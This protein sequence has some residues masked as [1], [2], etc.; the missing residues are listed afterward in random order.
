MPNLVIVSNRLPVSVKKTDGKLEFYPS[1]GGLARGLI[2][3]TKKR[4]TKWIG[5]PGIPSD[6]LS[7]SER[8]EIT[9]ELKKQRCYPIFLTKKQID[10]YYNGYSNSVLWPL[11]HDLPIRTGDNTKTWEAYRSIN[12]IFAAEVERLSE[13][14]VN[15]WVHDYQLMLVPQMLRAARPNDHIGFFLHT[16]FPPAKLFGT[17]KHATT[18]AEGLLGADLVGFHTSGYAQNFSDSCKLLNIGTVTEG[19]VV[20]PNRS[21]QIS[22]FPIG[23]D[24]AKFSTAAKQRTVQTHYRRLERKYAGKKVIVTVDRLDPTKGFVERLE[25]YQT[26]LSDQPKLH[27][28]IVMVMLAIPSRGEIAEYQR[29]RLRVEKLVSDINDTFGTRRWHPVEY[30]H[31]TMPFDELAALYQRA[32]IAFVA[33][34]RDGMNLVAKEY[35]AS[36]SKRHGMLVLSQ[37]AGAAEELKDAVQVDPARPKTLVRGLHKALTMPKTELRKRTGKMQ[38]HLQEFTIHNWADNFMDSLQRP[39]AVAL[40]PPR[41][42]TLSALER[43]ALA[44][45]YH[46]AKKR[47]LLFDYDGVLAPLVDE[48]EAA[49]PSKEVLALLKRLSRN[50]ANELVIISG[51][52]KDDLGKWFGELPIALAAEHGALFRRRG[53]KNWHKTSDSGLVWKRQ[54]RDL[55]EYYTSLTPGSFVEHKEW[56]VVWHYRTASTFFANKH[57]VA[58]RRLLKPLLRQYNLTLKEGHKVA[59]VHPAD[60]NKGRIAQ[61]WLIHDH[62]FVLAIGD[63]TTDE[64]MF[65]VLPPSAYSIKVGR[66]QTAARFRTTS[67]ANVLGLLRRL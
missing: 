66:G 58:I 43:Q 11:F 52:S 49:V 29:L 54:V 32:D 2:G 30:M 59:E 8:R 26:L 24:Y 5:W 39:R 12:A 9:K 44:G 36:R 20:L 47:L 17:C 62:D 67:V 65:A 27:G 50:K 13:P 16:P 6:N 22:V 56:S 35:V 38:R 53:G 61:E 4:G 64:D 23:I 60:I 41:A 48:P 37:T 42:K 40:V 46:K 28:K 57:L 15:I 51:R 63:D 31:Q 18:L 33:P 10:G 55:F 34:L 3:Y 14:G 25:A 45:A 1:D 21:V 19:Q 7:E